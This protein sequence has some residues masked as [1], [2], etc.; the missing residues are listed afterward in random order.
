MSLHDDELRALLAE[1]RQLDRKATDRANPS[2]R[3]EPT[4]ERQRDTSWSR[5]WRAGLNE[6]D[7]WDG[8]RV[9]DLAGRR[10]RAAPSLQAMWIDPEET[11][12]KP[13]V[14]PGKAL[15]ARLF[16]LLVTAAVVGL[17]AWLIVPEVS[18]RLANVNTVTVRD[19]VLTAQPVPLGPTTP[20][21]VE[22]L[23]VDAGHLPSGVLP[24][25][26]SI[27]RLRTSAPDAFGSTTVDL[28][29]PFD[30]RFVSV[31]TLQGAVTQPGTPVAT[32]YDPRKLLADSLTDGALVDED[33]P[34]SRQ[35]RAHSEPAGSVG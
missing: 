7:P 23:W 34:W 35:F 12:F 3:A 24:A 2:G 25:G 11:P 9:D 20:A 21:I 5:T 13:Q 31:D 1:G 28:A 8:D 15:P 4:A 18:F 26:T 32:V 29:V 10:G 19:G 17:L 22:K 6:P 16:S 14:R 27:A 33:E 30:A